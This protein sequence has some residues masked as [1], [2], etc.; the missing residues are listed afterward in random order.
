MNS[1]IALFF[2]AFYVQNFNQ[3]AQNLGIILVVKQLSISVLQNVLPMLK[4][5]IKKKL[6]QKKYN[7]SA[8]AD[9]L[10]HNEEDKKTQ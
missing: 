1:N 8:N 6:L 7:D 10:A 4:V 3:L 2:I 5:S 9:K